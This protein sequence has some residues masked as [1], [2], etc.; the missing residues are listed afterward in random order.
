MKWLRRMAFTVLAATYVAGAF[1]HVVRFPPPT[2]RADSI[3]VGMRYVA[4]PTP[5]STTSISGQRCYIP[6]ELWFPDLVL[7][8]VVPSLP[9]LR[10][11]LTPGVQRQSSIPFA[12]L[13]YSSFSDKAPPLT[14]NL[15]IVK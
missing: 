10:D 13:Y 2:V 8:R 12:R 11:L 1:P 9:P 5:T 15:V 7:T 14:L 3:C 4:R 6:P